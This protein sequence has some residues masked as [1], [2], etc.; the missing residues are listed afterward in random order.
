MANKKNTF[1]IGQEERT[2][3]KKTCEKLI[4]VYFSFSIEIT[5]IFKKI[6]KI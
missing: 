3:K 6:S 5:Y 2:K 4:D 1:K